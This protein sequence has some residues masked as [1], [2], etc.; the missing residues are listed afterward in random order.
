MT[1]SSYAAIDGSFLS[2]MARRPAVVWSKLLMWQDKNSAGSCLTLPP[3]HD[4]QYYAHKSWGTEE[5]T[6]FAEAINH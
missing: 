2:I 4:H 6:Q 5:G 3:R 1:A